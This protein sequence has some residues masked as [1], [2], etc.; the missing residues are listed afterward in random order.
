[1]NRLVASAMPTSEK[2][3]SPSACV[4]CEISETSTPPTRMPAASPNGHLGMPK[5][6]RPSRLR[7]MIVTSAS[8][9]VPR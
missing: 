8:I 2:I 3:S 1:M 5:V 9:G 6:W 4:R 7:P